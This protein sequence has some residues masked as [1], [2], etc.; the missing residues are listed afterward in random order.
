MHPMIVINL[1]VVCSIIGKKIKKQHANK[2]KIYIFVD[3]IA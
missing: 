2:T 1:T 3:D